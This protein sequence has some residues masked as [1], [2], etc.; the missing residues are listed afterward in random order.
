MC[1]KICTVKKNLRKFR[2]T[3]TFSRS[4]TKEKQKNVEFVFDQC[5]SALKFCLTLAE[6][7]Q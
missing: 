6:K 2:N 1:K 7:R 5:E 3:V 4:I